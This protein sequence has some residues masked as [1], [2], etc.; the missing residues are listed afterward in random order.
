MTSETMRRQ[1][2][3]EGSKGP[4]WSET[5]GS[6]QDNRILAKLMHEAT[7]E[8]NAQIRGGTRV[9]DWLDKSRLKTEREIRRTLQHDPFR[10]LLLRV[11]GI[12]VGFLRFHFLVYE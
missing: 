8:N 7:E 5:C 11:D 9:G 10:H 4:M 2:V 1:V 12:P 6:E 3:P